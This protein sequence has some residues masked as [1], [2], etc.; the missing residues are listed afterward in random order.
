MPTP[1]RS[2]RLKCLDCCCDSALEVRLCPCTDCALHVYRFGTNPHRS[3]KGIESHSLTIWSRMH[4]A[5]G[6]HTPTTKQ[7]QNPPPARRKTGKRPCKAAER[8]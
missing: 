1:L 7:A 3:K 8:T 6:K 4:P 2:I 5:K